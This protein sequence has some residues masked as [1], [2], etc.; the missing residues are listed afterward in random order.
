VLNINSTANLKI[1]RSMDSAMFKN[2]IR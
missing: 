1:A 2:K